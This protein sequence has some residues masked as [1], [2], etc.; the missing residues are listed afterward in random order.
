[1]ARTTTRHNNDADNYVTTCDVPCCSPLHVADFFWISP[2]CNN[3]AAA[4][5]ALE[6]LDR[7]WHVIVRIVELTQE[8]VEGI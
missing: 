1:M 3:E 8:V 6:V 7:A 5:L 4:K 2:V